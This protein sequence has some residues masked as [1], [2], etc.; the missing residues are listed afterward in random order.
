[1][2]EGRSLKGQVKMLLQK[3][4]HDEELVEALLVGCVVWCGVAWCG[5]V[6]CGG[7]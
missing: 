7:V 2:N 1:M 5:V 3:A 6:W 4:K